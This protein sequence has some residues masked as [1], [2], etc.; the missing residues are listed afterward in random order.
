MTLKVLIWAG[1]GSRS[2]SYPRSRSCSLR[3]SKITFGLETPTVRL[4]KSWRLPRKQMLTTSSTNFPRWKYSVF[5]YDS[6][7]LIRHRCLLFT[8]VCFGGS[9]EGLERWI[10]H[11]GFYFETVK[12]F[13]FSDK[14]R[15]IQPNNFRGCKVSNNYSWVIQVLWRL[16][17]GCGEHGGI[18]WYRPI[19]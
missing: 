12:K 1:C 9:A 14:L 17:A 13:L 11:V 4:K 7:G 3:R 15:S 2:V 16:A 6:V 10:C 19:Y 5:M 18:D 8:G